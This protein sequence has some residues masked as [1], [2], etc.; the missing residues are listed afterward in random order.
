MNDIKLRVARPSDAAELLALYA[1]YVEDTAISFETVVPSLEEFT[2]R[3][4]HKLPRYPYIVAEKDGE[5]LGYMPTSARLS[6]AL[7]ICGRRRRQYICGATAAKWAS[8]KCCTPRLRALPV[9][10][11]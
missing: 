2:E 7:R 3:M 6:G 4:V 9:L 8:A 1:P 5:L 11:A 10:R